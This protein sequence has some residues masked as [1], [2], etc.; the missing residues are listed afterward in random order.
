MNENNPQM[1]REKK[2]ILLGRH[3]SA[4]NRENKSSYPLCQKL[5]AIT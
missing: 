4:Q 3:S 1:K 2:N 5:I